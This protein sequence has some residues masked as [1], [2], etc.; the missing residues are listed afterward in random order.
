MIIGA[1]EPHGAEDR[2][3]VLATALDKTSGFTT[4]ASSG[5]SYVVRGV[6]VEASLDGF[7]CHLQRLPTSGRFDRL[8]VEIESLRCGGS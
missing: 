4:G 1:L 7:R 6:R 8:K 3:E 2:F 5:W